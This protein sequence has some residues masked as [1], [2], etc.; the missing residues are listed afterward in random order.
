MIS[1]KTMVFNPFQVNTYILTDE[2]K[3]CIIVDAAAYETH[4]EQAIRE[5]ICENSLNPVLLVTTHCHI[6]HILGNSFIKAT[7]NTEIVSN[8]DDEFLLNSAKESSVIFGLDLKQLPPIDKYLEGGDIIRFGNS[9]LDIFHIPGHSPGS[10]A[11]Y[12]ASQGFVLTG[13]VLFNRSIGRTDLPGGNFNTLL[14]GI[15]E[16]LMVL[17]GKT[18]VYPGHGQTTTIADEKENN[19]FI[20]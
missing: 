10:I 3:D 17:P 7:Y 5:Y 1:I 14:T 9:S 15:K 18:I 16:K 2:T 6:D 11:L 13:D 19:S 12:S 4:E 20:N 8:R